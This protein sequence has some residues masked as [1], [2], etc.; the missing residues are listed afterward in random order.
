MR[1]LVFRHVPFEGLGR[2]ADSLSERGIEFEY[3]DLYLPGTV[4]PPLIGYDGLILLGG[5]MSVNDRLAGSISWIDIELQIIRVA[6]RSD[7]PVLG[8]CLGAQMIAK[9]MGAPVR[10]NAH[11]EVGWFPI[12]C[13]PSAAT[14]RLFHGLRTEAVF[15][16]HGETF[17]LPPGAV[18]LATS[19]LCRNQA[20]RMGERVYGLQFHLEVTPEMIE[21]WCRQDENS[22]DVRELAAPLDATLNSSRMGELAGVIF[23]GW[24]DMLGETTKAKAQ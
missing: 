17:D 22:C 15:H 24:C 11:A 1:I 7:L 8:V 9:A 18:L 16:W 14:D 2:I 5:P 6:V 13:T 3:A 20:F 21:D 12:T 23:G 19:E 4:P 10:R